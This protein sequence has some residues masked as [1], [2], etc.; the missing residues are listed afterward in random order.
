MHSSVMTAIAAAG[1]IM[2]SIMIPIVFVRVH[3]ITICAT[4]WV[5]GS[6]PVVPVPVIVIMTGVIYI[7]VPMHSLLIATSNRV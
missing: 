3:S 7:A 4:T 6:K 2:T 1:I 5:I